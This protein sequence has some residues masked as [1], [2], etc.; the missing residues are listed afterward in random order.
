MRTDFSIPIFNQVSHCGPRSNLNT[1]KPELVEKRFSL[2]A[3]CSSACTPLPRGRL[4]EDQSL[5]MQCSLQLTSEWRSD[6][7]LKVNASAESKRTTRE[8]VQLS[9]LAALAKWK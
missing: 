6:R 2:S 1:R 7:C 5:S 9:L 3:A 8:D 4:P